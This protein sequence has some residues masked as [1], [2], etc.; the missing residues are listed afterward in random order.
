MINFG[1]I[2]MLFRKKYKNKGLFLDV[3]D[4]CYLIDKR[5]NLNIEK[6]VSE[7][8]IKDIGHTKI[9]NELEYLVLKDKTNLKTNPETK[10]NYD[11]FEINPGFNYQDQFISTVALIKETSHLSDDHI[12][13]YT[14]RL[15]DF[16]G[17]L[18]TNESKGSILALS[19]KIILYAL[20]IGKNN[21][22][23]F[24]DN[25]VKDAALMIMLS[26]TTYCLGRALH[27]FIVKSN[28]DSKNEVEYNPINETLRE[29]ILKNDILNIKQIYK[30][31]QKDHIQILKTG[32]ILANSLVKDTCEQLD[33]KEMIYNL[34]CIKEDDIL[35]KILKKSICVCIENAECDDQ[36]LEAIRPVFIGKTH[37]PKDWDTNEELKN[38]PYFYDKELLLNTNIRQAVTYYVNKNESVINRFMN[39]YKETVEK[40]YLDKIE[41]ENKTQSF[42]NT[43][44]ELNAEN[45][46]NFEKRERLVKSFETTL[47][48]FNIEPS[49]EPKEYHDFFLRN[50]DFYD[51]ADKIFIVGDTIEEAHEYYDGYI[52]KIEELAHLASSNE[53]VKRLLINECTTIK[54]CL[55]NIN[56]FARDKAVKIDFQLSQDLFNATFF[57]DYF[58]ILKKVVICVKGPETKNVVIKYLARFF[59]DHLKKITKALVDIL[60]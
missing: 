8:L 44:A 47:S 53:E 30:E 48:G 50:E 22:Y 43:L 13:L 6:R 37:T 9:F 54:R 33:N 2:N 42:E 10:E 26:A 31:C 18:N 1:D 60:N 52:Q 40:H 49:T 16:F 56:G 23:Y 7:R 27:S 20:K 28:E 32:L 19:Y 58:K 25:S 14:D 39:D 46:K 12:L 45:K 36:Y 5:V 41:N 57:D 51:D 35:F 24:E 29:F 4:L 55:D 17:P 15:N 38:K 3:K 59:Q 34:F 11:T 21:S